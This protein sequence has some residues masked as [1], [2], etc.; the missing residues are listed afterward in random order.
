MNKIAT[1][2]NFDS[3]VG[4]THNFAGLSFGNIASTANKKKLSNPKLAALQSLEKMYFLYKQGF[5]QG[6]IPPQPRPCIKTLTNL[7]FTSLQTALE[8]NPTLIKNLCSSSF[9]W[10][11]NMATFSPSSDCFDNKV[12]ITPANLINKFHRSIEADTSYELLQQ[13]FSDPRYFRVHKALFAHDI[14]SDEGAANHNRLCSEHANAG[15]EI[16]VY[17]KLAGFDS[18]KTL[19]F[20]ARQSLLASQS[21][22][23]LHNLKNNLT[24]FLEQN[25][26]SIDEGAFHNDVVCVMNENVILCHELAFVDQQ[27]AL[28]SIKKAYEDNFNQELFIIVIN[29][30]DLS[31]NNAVSSYL[32]NSQ[33][34]TKT[35]GKMLLFAP[36]ESSTNTFSNNA[37][38]KIIG[39]NNPIDEV[40]F[41]DI[42]QSMAN[43]GG[44]ACLRL[45]CVLS[46]EELSCINN[47]VFLNQA[48]YEELKYIINTYYPENFD[49]SY[50]LDNNYLYSI[51][52]ALDNIYQVLG[53]QIR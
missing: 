33:L 36:L 31:I 46:A 35:N 50:L 8:Q 20:P 49:L 40:A 42:S 19:K 12:H 14:F 47:K 13:I 11:A 30:K 16:F 28:L 18:Q 22:A 24:F 1:E 26:E 23:R 41:F 7:G 4:P 45:R 29:N 39:D 5:T 51:K 34:L 52:K 25:P 21:I 43:G 17:G 44:P 6:I 3:L 27:K 48:N 37:I 53:L 32:F 9:M 38:Q 15:L 10:A 2:V